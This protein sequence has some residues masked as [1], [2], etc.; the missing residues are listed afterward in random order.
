[1]SIYTRIYT[2]ILYIYIHTYTYIYIYIYIYIHIYT[3]IYIYIHMYVYTYIYIYTHIYCRLYN[4]SDKSSNKRP[5][6]R[7]TFHNQG[8]SDIHLTGY[9][10]PVGE[11]PALLS[12]GN[13]WKSWRDYG[14]VGW[15]EWI[16]INLRGPV[17]SKPAESDGIEV[18]FIWAND[19]KDFGSSRNQE[20]GVMLFCVCNILG[21]F[22]RLDG[23]L[24]QRFRS[25]N[26]RVPKK[27]IKD[28]LR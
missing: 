17:S 24:F 21:V 10:E 13:L 20:G 28:F 23:M 12:L 19:W 22:E 7:C 6:V 8:T 4:F 16:T 11:L 1:M 25:Q 27:F 26:S 3:Y 2:H 18:L 15:W 9:F 14:G 5:G